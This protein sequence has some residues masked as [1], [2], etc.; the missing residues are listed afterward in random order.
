RWPFFYPDTH[1]DAGTNARIRWEPVHHF[2]GRNLEWVVFNVLTA[3]GILNIKFL[4]TSIL[5]DFCAA[6]PSLDNGYMEDLENYWTM[7][8][9]WEKDGIITRHKAFLQDYAIRIVGEDLIHRIVSHYAS[10]YWRSVFQG[11]LR[12]ED[13]AWRLLVSE[14]IKDL[15]DIAHLKE[16]RLPIPS[17]WAFSRPILDSL[18]I[19]SHLAA[20]LEQAR[21][22]E[23]GDAEKV[24]NV[25]S[26]L[27]RAENELLDQDFLHRDFWWRSVFFE[28]INNLPNVPQHLLALAALAPRPRRLSLS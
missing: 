1:S 3:D 12:K 17:K 13:H 8:I 19:G 14:M 2:S 24:L 11:F 25:Y 16:G 10:T 5:S 28:R 4:T 23:A 26:I 20:A 18:A 21:T 15:C 7:G 22:A 27:E 6:T 9:V